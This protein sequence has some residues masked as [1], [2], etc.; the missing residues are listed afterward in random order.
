MNFNYTNTV[1]KD[2]ALKPPN[3]WQASFKNTAPACQALHFKVKAPQGLLESTDKVGHFLVNLTTFEYISKQGLPSKACKHSP[4]VYISAGLQSV[5]PLSR[6]SN[7]IVKKSKFKNFTI[8][9]IREVD[10]E[11]AAEL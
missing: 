11:E 5:K 8:K 1:H 7:D 10:L 6:Q 4:C 9:T 2:I 3:R